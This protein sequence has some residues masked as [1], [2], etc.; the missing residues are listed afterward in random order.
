MIARNRRGVQAWMMF[1]GMM[2]G[3]TLAACQPDPRISVQKFLELQ[4]RA[5]LATEQTE[6]TAPEP[7]DPAIIERVLGPYRVGAGDTL[8]VSLAGTDLPFASPVVC[9][10]DRAGEIH[11][12]LVGGVN[13]LDQTLEDVER[14]IMQAY[15]PRILKDVAVHVELTDFESTKVMVVGAVQVPGFV[16]LR[17]IE[18]NVLVG[19][20]MAGGVTADATG[21]A[22][23]RRLK[24][25]GREITFDL[26]EPEDARAALELPPLDNGDII[27]VEAAP[28]A[29]FVG[30]LVN[31]PGPIVLE[32]GTELNLLQAIAAAGGLRTDLTPREG[33][34][35][36][37]MPDGTDAQ[38]K[39]N[40]DK[41]AASR[42][43]NLQLAAG[44]ILW[45]PHTLETRIQEFINHN[46][47]LRAGASVNYNVSGVEFM[48]RRR[49]QASR[50]GGGGG[51]QDSFDPYG[52]L[53]RNQALQGL[54]NRP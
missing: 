43:P 4:Q 35:I 2:L 29:V 34:L 40:L 22:T 30:G 45:V 15:V 12:P 41:L 48:N 21:R 7:P 39:I 9:R 32:P 52:F 36:H 5:A 3:L 13:V 11:L 6:A 33:T 50:T 20:I 18:R 31:M 27:M 46:I 8:T 14:S 47:F 10:I 1:V 24:D 38:V 53:L 23:L 51:L 42:E 49:L 37:R 17:H 54:S 28:R 19:V 26:T 25:P 44:D 16:R